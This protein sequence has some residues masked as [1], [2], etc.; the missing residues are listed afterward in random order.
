M[1]NF[2]FVLC[3]LDDGDS[4]HIKANTPI[5][6][7]LPGIC[8]NFNKCPKIKQLWKDKAIARDQLTI[9]NRARKIICCP[10]QERIS[11]KSKKIL[12]MSA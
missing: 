12:I 11:Q 9:C 3:D 7:G 2:Y 6:N 10:V 1:L 5:D 4:C 8:I